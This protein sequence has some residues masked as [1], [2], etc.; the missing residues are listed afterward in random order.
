MPAG[1]LKI[2]CVEDNPS[3]VEFTTEAL[4]DSKLCINLGA[5]SDG[6]EALAFLRREGRYADALRPYHVR[7]GLRAPHPGEAV[8]LCP[9]RRSHV[10]VRA[11]PAPFDRVSG[12]LYRD[13]HPTGSGSTAAWL[14]K[15]HPR[16]LEGRR[17][18]FS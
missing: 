17:C 5:V 10:T 6:A 12:R 11:M 8:P 16:G 18:A 15:G 2:L 1:P 13:P 4:K 9:A 7:N 3:D 14:A